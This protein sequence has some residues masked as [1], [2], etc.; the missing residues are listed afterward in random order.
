MNGEFIQIDQNTLVTTHSITLHEVPR[1]T[2]RI[3]LA[4]KKTKVRLDGQTLVQ[5]DL[6]TVLVGDDEEGFPPYG[7]T[8]TK[9]LGIENILI[10]KVAGQPHRPKNLVSLVQ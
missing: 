8:T 4:P 10:S 1:Y 3:I 6:N 9:F 5:T 2:E 7:N